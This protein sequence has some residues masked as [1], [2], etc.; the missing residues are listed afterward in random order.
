MLCYVIN[1]SYF[2]GYLQCACKKEY[3]TLVTKGAERYVI[4]EFFDE[5]EMLDHLKTNSSETLDG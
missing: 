5:N 3:L 4:V 2:I 1:S